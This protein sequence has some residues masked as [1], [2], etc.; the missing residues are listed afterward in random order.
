[1]GKT[2]DRMA[3]AA[4]YL[5]AR[6]FSLSLIA[7]TDPNRLPDPAVALRA[8]PRGGA[9]IWRAYDKKPDYPAARALASGLRAR[10]GILLIAGAPD[11][12][13]RLGID[14]I[15]LPEY[16]ITRHR[17]G[18]FR[19]DVPAVIVTAACHSEKA[20]IAASRAGVDAVLISPALPT[21]SHPDG[22]SLGIPR[23]A[24]LVRVADGL[25]LPAYALGGISTPAHVARLRGTGAKG[26]AGI[27]FILGSGT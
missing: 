12:A 10:D 14:G 15:H 16:S 8:V 5:N 2:S 6:P 4:R 25:G 27:G 13:R 20:V 23:F 18:T 21:E 3:R 19:H 11:F 26:I 22:K 24:R 17:H 7:V 9:L 1:M